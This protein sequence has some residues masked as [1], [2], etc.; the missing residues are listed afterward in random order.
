M[1]GRA[2]S[3]GHSAEFSLKM[4][5]LTTSLV[6]VP[7]TA[8]TFWASGYDEFPVVSRVERSA[9][10]GQFG[11]F[12]WD[13]ADDVSRPLR[14]EERKRI[15]A[16]SSLVEVL[17]S[18]CGS[19]MENQIKKQYITFLIYYYLFVTWDDTSHARQNAPWIYW[20]CVTLLVETPLLFIKYLKHDTSHHMLIETPLL[21]IKIFKTWHITSHARQNNAWYWSCRKCWDTIYPVLTRL[22]L[23]ATCFYTSFLDSWAITLW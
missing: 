2:N 16:L 20:I 10:R 22:V 12:E 21:F 8:L 13:W 14:C 15:S 3:T 18:V 4:S 23:R 17:S 9:K 6:A 19:A 11:C 7:V 1:M 5:K